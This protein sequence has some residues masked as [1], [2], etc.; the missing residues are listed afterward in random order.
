[1]ELGAR[2]RL[3]PS[4]RNWRIR[5]LSLDVYIS[6]RWLPDPG[7][8]HLWVLELTKR[9]SEFSTFQSKEKILAITSSLNLVL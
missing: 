5:V 2:V 6:K 4:H 8:S 7:E 3:L 9:P 1:M